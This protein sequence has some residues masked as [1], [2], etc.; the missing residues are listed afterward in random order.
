ADTRLDMMY[1]PDAVRAM[2]ELMQADAATLLNRNAYNITA[3]SV[4][5]HDLASAIAARISGFSIDYDIDPVRQSIADSWPRSL[6]DS[7][8]RQEWNWAPRFDIDA[9][10]DDMLEQIH[11][12][13]KPAQAG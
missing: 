9:M 2:I 6:D 12:N 3:M 11:R 5:P 7:A 4:T 10:S 8:A 1:M 13:L